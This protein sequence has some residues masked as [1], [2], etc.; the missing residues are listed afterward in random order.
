MRGPHTAIKT[1]VLV[2]VFFVRAVFDQQ[3]VVLFQPLDGLDF[4][5]GFIRATSPFERTALFSA[6]LFR[7]E[8]FLNI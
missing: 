6:K 2:K 4:D 5:R 7:V 1:I 8:L 3:F